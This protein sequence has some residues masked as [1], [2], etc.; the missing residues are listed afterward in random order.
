MGCTRVCEDAFFAHLIERVET[1]EMRVTGAPE[2]RN[3]LKS[4]QNK[5]LTKKL[6]NATLDASP[7][8][9]QTKGKN[10]NGNGNGSSS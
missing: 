2:L 4:L 8:R 5:K 1:M 9:K 7:E 3:H 10:N 6:G